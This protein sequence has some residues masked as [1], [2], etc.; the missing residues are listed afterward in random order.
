[1]I[2]MGV[3]ASTTVRAVAA[4]F[5]DCWAVEVPSDECVRDILGGVHYHA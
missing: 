4:D 3:E 1:M 5:F 2:G